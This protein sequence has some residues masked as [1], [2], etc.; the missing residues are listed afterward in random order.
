MTTADFNQ[1]R[2]SSVTRQLTL[3]QLANKLII[4]LCVLIV[5][6]LISS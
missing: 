5:N 1:Q 6:D 4:R 2:P 3:N